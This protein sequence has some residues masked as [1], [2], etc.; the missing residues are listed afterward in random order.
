MAPLPHGHNNETTPGLHHEHPEQLIREYHALHA[1]STE[2]LMDEMKGGGP[3]CSRA[4]V[5]GPFCNQGLGN[6]FSQVLNAFAVA[7][8][9]NRTFMID[10]AW[11]SG[12]VNYFGTFSY[13]KYDRRLVAHW[14]SECKNTSVASQ[15]DFG[16]LNFHPGGTALGKNNTQKRFTPRD[17]DSFNWHLEQSRRD[18]DRLLCGDLGAESSK[19]LYVLDGQNLIVPLIKFNRHIRDVGIKGR[20]HVLFRQKGINTY[21]MLHAALFDFGGSPPLSGR[22]QGFIHDF[23][24][25]SLGNTAS[26]GGQ[27]NSRFNLTMHVRHMINFGGTKQ[28]KIDDSALACAKFAID[29]VG[30]N[31]DGPCRVYIASD[32][33]KNRRRIVNGLKE[34]LPSGCEI[35]VFT[36]PEN[37]T[38]ATSLNKVTAQRAGYRDWGTWGD[39]R[40]ASVLDLHMV[41][42]S[43][44]VIGTYMSTF[45]E[46]AGAFPIDDISVSSSGRTE[47]G[48]SK[49]FFSFRPDKVGSCER[50]DAHW[51]DPVFVS[52]P[53]N[54][55]AAESFASKCEEIPWSI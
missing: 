9:L 18:F 36:M 53:T 55:G 24:A 38:D 27:L 34:M 50:I 28:P 19:F 6:C 46:L 41:A 48:F 20:A 12:M 7:V 22:L 11:N 29:K 44:I 30:L 21:G 40:W 45:S 52:S 25:E 43:D 15:P 42:A 4:F 5:I 49:A 47:P 14:H 32:N 10:S 33:E 26:A 35:V 31:R 2:N 1:R 17:K 8:V 23:L 16:V 3:G 39:N 51:P 54:M 13:A 37:S